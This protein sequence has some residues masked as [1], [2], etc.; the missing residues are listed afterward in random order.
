MAVNKEELLETIANMTVLEVVELVEA[1]EEKFGVS[2]AM[3]AVAAAPRRRR[4]RARGG[5][6]D[7]VRRRA[8]ELRI[9]EGRGHQGRACPDE[10]RPEGGEGPRRERSRVGSRGGIEGR[11]GRG[12]E[13]ARGSRGE[14]GGPVGGAS[15]RRPH[16]HLSRGREDLVVASRTG[17][18]TPTRVRPGGS[19][20]HGTWSRRDRRPRQNAGEVRGA[21][22]TVPATSSEVPR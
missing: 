17:R 8:H 5:G 6:A 14:R 4:R 3:T 15:A 20:K 10:P 12:A 19:R 18:E 2:A 11:G 16:R 7:R 22:P 9:R 1:M 13:A 21:G